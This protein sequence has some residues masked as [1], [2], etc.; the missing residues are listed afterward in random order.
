MWVVIWETTIIW[1]NVLIYHW[2]TLWWTS[3]NPWKRHP[4]I[5]NNVLIW[6]WAKLFG[7]ITIWNDSQIWWWAVVTKDV[8]PHCIVVWNPWKIVKINWEKIVT[9][10]VDQINLPDPISQKIDAIEK[11][12]EILKTKKWI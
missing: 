6:A 9:K 7:P 2:V 10:E 8:P 3:L 11:E 12:I 1:E 5:W 4:T